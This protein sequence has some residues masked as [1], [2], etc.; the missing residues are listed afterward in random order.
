MNFD[1]ITGFG[2][3]D[4]QRKLRGNYLTG[5][6]QNIVDLAEQEH[7]AAPCRT[8]K[9]G[10]W[11]IFVTNNGPDARSS[12]EMKKLNPPPL[13]TCKWVDIDDG[14]PTWEQ[15]LAFAQSVAQGHEFLAYTSRSHGEIRPDGS[16]KRKYRILFPHVPMDYMAHSSFNK[17]LNDVLVQ[18]G[19]TPD[20]VSERPNQICYLPNRGPEYHWHH[21]PGHRMDLGGEHF[22]WWFNAARAAWEQDVNT[23]KEFTG[24]NETDRSPVAAFCRK[25]SAAEMMDTYGWISHDG[26]NFRC[27]EQTTKSYATKVD[28]GG[29]GWV[30]A[31]GSVE[32]IM[33]TKQGDG[34]DIYRVYQCGGNLDQAL[35]YARQC[36]KE[37]DDRRYGA[38]TVEH[39]N[40]LWQG[41]VGVGGDA[42]H[43][44]A[45]RR[46]A[47]AESA[48]KVEQI[49]TENIPVADERL[50]WDIGWPPG[51]I[52][53]AAKWIYAA[54]RRPVKQFAIAQA[55]YL[56]AGMVGHRYHVEETGLN[57]F[58]I[59]GGE[60]GVGKGESYRLRSKLGLT[61]FEMCQDAPGFV[62]V[63]GNDIPASQQGLRKMFMDPYTTRASYK[64]DA[65]N[66]LNMLMD[67]GVG[68]VGEG[69]R[70]QLSQFWDQ[71]GPGKMVGAVSYSKEENTVQATQSPAYTVGLDT[72]VDPV[73][74]FLGT[75]AARLG[76]AQ[77]FI[78]FVYTGGP[79]KSNRNKPKEVPQGL[80]ARIAQIWQHTRAMHGDKV[81]QVVMPTHL[82]DRIM[83]LE[84]QYTDL[85]NEKGEHHKIY[86][87]AHMNVSRLAG[88]LAVAENHLNPVISDEMFEYSLRLA[89]ISYGDVSRI[90]ASGEAGS[91]ESVRVAKARAAVQEYITMS[92]GKRR[93]V[94]R[95]PKSLCEVSDVIP[96]KFFMNRL[97]VFK[98][99]KGSDQ[100]RTTQDHIRKAIEELVLAQVLVPVT[101]PELATGRGIIVSGRV[102]SKL[103]AVGP[104]F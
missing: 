26:V 74:R 46:Q 71:S 51:V 69:L 11:A 55:F 7:K 23:Y 67:S 83:D 10:R 31:S 95:I 4:S 75:E 59:V 92:S 16:V 88:L 102:T 65:D 30:T 104:D 89:E 40:E 63:F 82:A 96:E 27:P 17:A 41:C 80:A 103:Y 8:D 54:S 64:E 18:W 60:S 28:E 85:V 78:Y 99:F 62:G 97:A 73:K 37:E 72:Q 66:M 87:R 15:V 98:D 81:Q 35:A 76:F 61:A 44:P 36:L 9:D 84:D 1:F 50:Q 68:S 38:A 48:A 21:Q 43:A 19:M 100:G 56:V 58:M 45:A 6:F 34:F 42:T 22:H 24:K 101:I 91:G 93:A 53:E 20:R 47:L 33:G 49:V 2:R 12:I 25:H 32:G 57:L 70:S 39:G 90:L 13:I 86:N 3:E 79:F 77:R 5:T 29:R 52:G 14:D 94:Y